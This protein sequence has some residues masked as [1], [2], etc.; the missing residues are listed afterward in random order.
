MK[1]S[2]IKI[3]AILLFALTQCLWGSRCAGAPAVAVTMRLDTNVVAVGQGTLLHVSAQVVPSLRPSADRIFSWYVDV[4]NT[5][6]VAA[7]ANYNAM[8]KSASDNDPQLSSKGANDGA[9]RR[10][11][12]DTF[13]NLP[14]AGVTN[15]VELMSIPVTGLTGGKTRFLV[16]AGTGADLSADFQ[17]APIGG[18]QPYVGGDYSAAFVDLTVTNS[19]PC[20][21][22][23][24]V[25]PLAGGGRPGGTFQLSFSPC[26][27]RTHTV[28]ARAALGD[29]PGWQA[30]P[31]APHNSGVVIVTNTTTTRFFRVRASSP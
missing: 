15:P 21:L 30:L 13:L 25:T 20:P 23:L 29:I 1:P 26:P 3:Y 14:G 22:S 11:I 28:E 10:A 4:L 24:V 6:G 5:N 2:S 9:N 7:G 8:L 27:G 17:V 18:G 31:G 19:V 16:Q 12:Y